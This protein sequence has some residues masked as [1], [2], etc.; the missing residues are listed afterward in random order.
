MIIDTVEKFKSLYERRFSFFIAYSSTIIKKGTWR[1]RTIYKNPFDL[2]LYQE[3]IYKTSPDIIIEI[4]TGKGGSTLFFMDILNLINPQGVIISIDKNRVKLGQRN[5][6][7]IHGRS[8]S[9]VVIDKVKKLCGGKKC[10][11]I[12]D[13][14]HLKNAVLEDL[15]NYGKF[16]GLGGY[17][18]VEDT[19]I[20]IFPGLTNKYGAGPLV[21]VKKFLTENDEFEIDI[22]C[23]RFLYTLAPFGF[24]KRVKS[25]A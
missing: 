17:M 2:L 9:P 20:D 8:Q 15:R 3:I 21:A 14:N 11:V 23:H 12:H 19:L 18:I 10:M 4:G 16:V 22:S 7:N 24:L 25:N 13:G 5:I 6:I 1:G